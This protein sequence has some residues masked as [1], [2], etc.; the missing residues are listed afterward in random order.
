MG[1]FFFLGGGGVDRR[2]RKWVCMGWDGMAS[3]WRG[4]P[5]QARARTGTMG[6]LGMGLGIGNEN[7]AA[8]RMVFQLSSVSRYLPSRILPVRYLP[9]Y[10]ATYLPFSIRYLPSVICHLPFHLTA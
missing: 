7:G 1:I 8:W 9:T 2:Q 10:I 5:G 4:E 3:G 6:L